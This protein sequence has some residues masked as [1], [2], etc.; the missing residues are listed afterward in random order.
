MNGTCNLKIALNLGCVVMSSLTVDYHAIEQSFLAFADSQGFPISEPL[1]PDGKIHRFRLEGDKHGEKS[2]A[3]CVWPEGKNFDDRPH[4]WI[5]DHH[6]GGEKCFWQ[7]YGKDN[8]P[9]RER[10]T[11]EERAAARVRR[12]TEQRREAEQRSDALKS[13]WR[14]YQAARSIEE[15]DEHPYTSSKHVTPRGGFSFGG[16]WCGLRVGDVPG[17]DGKI[18]RNTLLIL[19][20]DVTSGKFQALHVVYGFQDKET[21]KFPKGWY[22]GTSGGCFPIGVDVPRGPVFVGEGI[23]TTLSWYQYWSEESGSVEP[24]AAIAA[25]DAGNLVKN[26][27]AIRAKYQGRDAFITG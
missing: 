21:G 14:I 23:G 19:C 6:R 3:Y 24:C 7:F 5:Q 10:P 9:P 13:A 27:A 1:K 25:M 18:L 11:D 22:R 12:E 2:G 26:A 20:M 4:G 17:K 8:P 16:Q 15:S